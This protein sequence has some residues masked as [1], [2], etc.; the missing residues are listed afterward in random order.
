MVAPSDAK[1]IS[2]TLQSM[3][4]EEYRTA[5]TNTSSIRILMPLSKPRAIPS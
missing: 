1:K 4:Q 2:H 5:L 3:A